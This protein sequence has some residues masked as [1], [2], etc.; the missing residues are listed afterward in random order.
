MVLPGSYGDVLGIGVMR[1]V[2]VAVP[3][4]CQSVTL[5]MY[6]RSE[7]AGGRLCGPGTANHSKSVQCQFESD[8]GHQ[9]WALNMWSDLGKSRSPLCPSGPAVSGHSRLAPSSRA[10]S[11]PKFS[12]HPRRPT[13][14]SQPVR[15]TKSSLRACAVFAERFLDTL[16]RQILLT[17]DALRI[18]LQQN[19]DT[20]ASPL[21]NLRRR[22]PT[23]QPR[24]QAGM[25]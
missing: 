5:I 23:I 14:G 20:V 10:I 21:R 3:N 2:L 12:L 13:H 6:I 25:T 1:V 17:R 19:S 7:R 15:A 8:R 24:R 22:D 16:P 11:V 9:L 4:A 18:H